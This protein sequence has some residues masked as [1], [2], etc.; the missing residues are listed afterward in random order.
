MRRPGQPSP[1]E[2]QASARRAAEPEAQLHS[3]L[4]VG[5]G[6]GA[7]FSAGRIT[8]GE[9]NQPFPRRANRRL[10]VAAACRG[11]RESRRKPR[12]PRGGEAWLAGEWTRQGWP[13]QG[14][15][16][17]SSSSARRLSVGLSGF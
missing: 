16:S 17:F 5:R 14:G 8:R 7:F 10:E 12:R 6:G 4:L 2:S 1:E 3:L 15:R 13:V 11:R 9:P